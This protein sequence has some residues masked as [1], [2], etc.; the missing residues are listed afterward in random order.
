MTRSAT[1]Q[2]SQRANKKEI[3]IAPALDE[4][5]VDY[6]KRHA[7]SKSEV[8]R[9]V[10]AKVADGDLPKRIPQSK[11]KRIV[12]WDSHGVFNRMSARARRLNVPVTEL[13]EA[14]LV[15]EFEA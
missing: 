13:F 4:R 3:R 1:S 7:M 15:E 9:S 5:L 11:S 6:A 8:V 12:F 10:M 14:A 2:A